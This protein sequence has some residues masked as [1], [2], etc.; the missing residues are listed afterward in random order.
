[1]KNNGPLI[2]ITQYSMSTARGMVLASNSFE[3]IDLALRSPSLCAGTHSIVIENNATGI[4]TLRNSDCAAANEQ[5]AQAFKELF[6]HEF[7]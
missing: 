1:M 6:P 4:R 2:T 7:N 3:S 5:L